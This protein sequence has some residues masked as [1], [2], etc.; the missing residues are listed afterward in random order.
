M[1]SLVVLSNSAHGKIAAMCYGLVSTLALPLE[2][3]MLPIIVGDLFGQKSF[4]KILGIFVSVNTAGFALGSPVMNIIYD[5]LGSYI[6]AFVVCGILMVVVAIAMQIVI[7]RAHQYRK[8]VVE[9][10]EANGVI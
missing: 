10:Y 4:N 5:L 1:F 8:S 2:T 9:R 3:V 7:R 6:L